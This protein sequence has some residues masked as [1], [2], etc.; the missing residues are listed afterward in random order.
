MLETCVEGLAM[1]C[2]SR[3]KYDRVEAVRDGMIS[4]LKRFK[5][6]S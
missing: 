2:W 6:R 4:R 1:I 5:G 3:L